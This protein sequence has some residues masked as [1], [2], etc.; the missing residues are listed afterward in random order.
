[1]NS[2]LRSIKIPKFYLQCGPEFKTI[3]DRPDVHSAIHDSFMKLH[4]IPEQENPYFPPLD[5]IIYVGERGFAII[6]NNVLRIADDVIAIKTEE[7]LKETGLDTYYKHKPGP[8]NQ[9][10]PPDISNNGLS[11]DNNLNYN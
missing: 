3:I 5:E 10:K 1:M 11:D 2:K 7:M 9:N 4:K 6:E 8:S